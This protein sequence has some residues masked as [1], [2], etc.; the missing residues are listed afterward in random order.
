MK[1]ILFSLLLL[2]A[3]AQAG[4]RIYSPTVKTLTTIVND[5][6]QNRP[7]DAVYPIMFIDAV[8]FECVKKSL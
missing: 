3:T 8:H 4:N 2:A 5:D 6:W 1:Q 7:L